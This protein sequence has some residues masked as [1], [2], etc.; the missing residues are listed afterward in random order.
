[1]ILNLTVYRPKYEAMKRRFPKA[2]KKE[3]IRKKWLKRFAEDKF[4][5]ECGEMGHVTDDCHLNV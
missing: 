2:A 3:R 4:C 5:T 1:M